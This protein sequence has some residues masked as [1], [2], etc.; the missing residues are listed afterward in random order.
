M[1]GSGTGFEEDLL[2]DIIFQRTYQLNDSYKE[3][4]SRAV[5]N[6]QNYLEYPGLISFNDIGRSITFSSERV[7]PTTSTNRPRI[8]LLFSNPHPHS[9]LQG[10]FLSPNIK[11]QESLF[12]VA[13]RDAGWILLPGEK[14]S[15]TQL[16]DICL[17]AEYQGP[18]EFVFY[19][20]YA[21]PTRYPDDIIRIFG[22]E[23]FTRYLAPEAN[24]EFKK[25]V[26][27]ANIVAVVTFNKGIFNLVANDK[28]DHYIDRLNSGDTIQ[29]QVSS[30][31]RYIPVFLSYPTGWFYHS[32]YRSLR[33]SS[34]IAI[35]EILN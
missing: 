28:V 3:I 11:G 19:C 20:Y 5:Q 26:D 7:I 33:K 22:K 27:E 35:Q 17:N 6:L 31:T 4:K 12:W 29:S 13:M 32:D 8:M 16:A 2:A 23:Y 24:D 9:I 1:C 14:Y 25:T 18:F 21:F 10:M 30:I 15:P 34:L